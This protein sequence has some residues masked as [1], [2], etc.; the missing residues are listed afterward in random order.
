MT[1]FQQL[2][3]FSS[4]FQEKWQDGSR[5]HGADMV[6]MDDMGDMAT[7]S[8][9]PEASLAIRCIATILEVKLWLK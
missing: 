8:G 4:F 5:D 7:C 3:G 1:S 2:K 9:I 6:G